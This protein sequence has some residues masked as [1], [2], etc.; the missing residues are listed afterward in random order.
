ME[1][2]IKGKKTSLLILICLF[3]VLVLV[4]VGTE[5]AR[6]KANFSEQ[7]GI[8]FNNVTADIL[9]IETIQYLGD[10]FMGEAR[11]I[12]PEVADVLYARMERITDL[13]PNF[14]MAYRVGGLTLSD[15]RPDLAVKFLNKGLE[16]NLGQSWEIPFYAGIISYFHLKDRPETIR[17]LKA[18]LSAPECPEFIKRLLAKV[19]SE[20]GSYEDALILWDAVYES[21]KTPTEKGLA[22]RHLLKLCSQ[23]ISS[24]KDK[25]L[26]AQAKAALKKISE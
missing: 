24:S 14:V 19:S 7:T 13:D 26:V 3:I 4:S 21:A 5:K 10:V 17:Y 11:K 12:T 23:L 6:V 1:K 8:G 15:A 16:N 20:V 25:D 22:R 18:A 9:W 2:I